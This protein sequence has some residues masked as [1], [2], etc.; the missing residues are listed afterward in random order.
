MIWIVVYKKTISDG[1]TEASSPTFQ[2]VERFHSDEEVVLAN[3]QVPSRTREVRYGAAIA[4]TP[5]P[6]VQRFT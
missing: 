2:K 1:P 3:L 4:Q 5:H 6:V